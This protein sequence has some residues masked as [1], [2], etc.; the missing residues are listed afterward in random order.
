MFNPHDDLYVAQRSSYDAV[1]IK[2]QVGFVY[3]EPHADFKVI[4]CGGKSKYESVSVPSN[5]MH[6]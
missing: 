1:G 3:H 6:T 5:P 4:Y 2:K